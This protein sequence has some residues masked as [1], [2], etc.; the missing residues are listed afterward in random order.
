PRQLAP[1]RDA[2]GL[3]QL[4]ALV[5]ELPRHRLECAR[6]LVDLARRPHV[7]EPDVP[8]AARDGAAG[9]G[10]LFDRARDARRH[11]VAEEEARRETERTERDAAPANARKQRRELASGTGD[12]ELAEHRTVA[13]FQWNG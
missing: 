1:G 10:E 5:D 11:D 8:V 12:E 6:E 13:A 4:L 3:N 9:G 7:V 2:F